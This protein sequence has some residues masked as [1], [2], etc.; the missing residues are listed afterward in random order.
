MKAFGSGIFFP[1]VSYNPPFLVVA[2]PRIPIF[3]NICH[4][5]WEAMVNHGAF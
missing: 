4:V 1:V 3:M 2:L 5:F